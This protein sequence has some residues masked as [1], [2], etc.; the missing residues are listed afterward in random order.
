MIWLKSRK[1]SF[2]STP[3]AWLPEL[4]PPPPAEEPPI[5]PPPPPCWANMAHGHASSAAAKTILSIVE[6]LPLRSITA[7]PTQPNN[8][9][10]RVNLDAVTLREAATQ[11]NI[12]RTVP[13][14]VPQGI[15]TTEPA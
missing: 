8:P 5:R 4:N 12:F 11:S 13:T 7:F 3:L 15:P 2:A 9:Q 10:R 14:L 1:S 6:P